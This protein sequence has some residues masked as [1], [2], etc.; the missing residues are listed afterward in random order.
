MEREYINIILEQVKLGPVSM[1]YN[2]HMDLWSV[3]GWIE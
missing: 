2:E 3:D 1:D